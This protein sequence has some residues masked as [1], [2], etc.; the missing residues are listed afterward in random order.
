MNAQQTLLLDPES[1]TSR[2]LKMSCVSM[3]R[4]S[5]IGKDDNVV[6]SR[7]QQEDGMTIEAL[8]V[9]VEASVEVVM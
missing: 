8:P 4:S 7:Q 3:V 9:E 5:R 2:V 6:C 1:H